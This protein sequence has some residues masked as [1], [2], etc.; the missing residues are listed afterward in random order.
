MLQE[1][2]WGRKIGVRRKNQTVGSHRNHCKDFLWA[3]R[4]KAVDLGQFSHHLA[5]GRSVLDD[6]T[7]N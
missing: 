4:W 1:F 7:E 5:E 3:L 2:M 6:H